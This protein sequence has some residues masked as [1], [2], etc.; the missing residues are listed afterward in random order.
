MSFFFSLPLVATFNKFK[1]RQVAL[2]AE[3]SQEFPE[4]HAYLQEVF[5][6]NNISVPLHRIIPARANKN[7]HQV[8]CSIITEALFKNCD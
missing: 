3:G 8:I 5:I 7:L 4:Y 1:W 6:Q 2:L